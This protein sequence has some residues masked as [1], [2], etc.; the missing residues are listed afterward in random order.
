MAATW[1]LTPQGAPD[2]RLG[3]DRVGPRQTAWALSRTRRG[4][5]RD[6]VGGLGSS[7]PGSRGS[8]DDPAGRP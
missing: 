5:P 3:A 8:V 6:G 7:I 1:R 2:R 4:Q